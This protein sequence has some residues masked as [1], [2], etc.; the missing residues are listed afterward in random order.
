MS[1]APSSAPPAPDPGDLTWVPDGCPGASPR[2]PRRRNQNYLDI[3]RLLS[4][5]D[6]QLGAFDISLRFTHLFWFGD[7]NY[8]LD[9]DIQVRAGPVGGRAGR[10]PLTSGPG[11]RVCSLCVFPP[12][13]QEILNYISRKEFEPLL[14]VDQLN[15]EREK[16]KVFLRFSKCGPAGTP[17]DQGP[18]G[19]LGSW[20]PWPRVFRLLQV[21]R[22]SPSRPPTATSEVPGTRTPGTSRSQLG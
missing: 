9:M 16:H 8:R 4:L 22:R 20:G 1:P 13:R 7:L 17:E 3:L 10:R 5:G 21:R 15:L 2:R 11:C 6:R 12:P 14:R 18:C 19:S